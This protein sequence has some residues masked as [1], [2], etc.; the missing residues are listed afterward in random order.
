MR[1]LFQSFIIIFFL[2]KCLFSQSFHINYE[3]LGDNCFY[4]LDYEK[5]FEMYE[6]GLKNN[7]DD[8]NLNWK[9]ARLLVNLGEVPGN[10]KKNY[11]SEAEKYANKSIKLNP[12]RSEGYTF[13]SA[14]IGN[15]A[16]YSGNKEKIIAANTMITLLKKAIQINPKD[17]IAYSILGSIERML[18]GISWFERTIGKIIYS[19]SIPEGSYNDAIKY[20]L[21]AIEI[22]NKL[23]R[24]HYELGLTYFDMKEYQKAKNEFEKAL[25]CPIQLKADYRRLELIKEKLNIISNR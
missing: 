8:Y 13:K 3:E 1:K 18:A 6:K 7:P 23:I 5:S 14:A 9:M 12:N 15:L 24:H 22:D 16:F 11:F 2:F 17:H 20:F 10:E 4:N 25:K 19:I 21:K